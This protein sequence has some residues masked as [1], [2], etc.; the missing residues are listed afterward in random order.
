M[1]STSPSWQEQRQIF[2]WVTAFTDRLV[3]HWA[4]PLTC[5]GL[6]L[7]PPKKWCETSHQRAQLCL[8]HSYTDCHAVVLQ[9]EKKKKHPP[10]MVPLCGPVLPDWGFGWHR[11]GEESGCPPLGF[12]SA[13]WQWTCL[14]AAEEGEV[15]LRAQKQENAL[16]IEIWLFLVS[17]FNSVYVLIT[18]TF[19]WM[20][21]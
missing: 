3:S 19:L 7:F 15:P 11:L 17:L 6:A 14:V 20:S 21:E 13:F 4:L 5:L 1:F 18:L 10:S 9:K 12:D 8:T 2:V 16:K